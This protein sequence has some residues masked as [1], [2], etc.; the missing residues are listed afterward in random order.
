MPAVARSQNTDTIT[1]GHGCDATALIAGSLQ[2]KVFV[3]T[4]LGAVQGD[5]IAPHTILAGAICVPHSAVVNAGS[6]KV[7]FGGI[8]AARIG[9]S[10][11][12]GVIISGS[13][14]VFAGG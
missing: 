13:S 4:K 10:A 2:T 11:D 12:G 9:D 14:N 8:A 7:F 6:S 1:T 3:N 5:P